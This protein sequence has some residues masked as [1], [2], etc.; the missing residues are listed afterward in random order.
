MTDW[1]PVFHVKRAPRT[2][3]AAHPDHRG[4]LPRSPQ[5]HGEDFLARI[6]TAV[7]NDD[8]S[9]SVQLDALPL[10]GSFLIREPRDGD[11]FDPVRKGGR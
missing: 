3:H 11:H 7:K 9:L 1:M 8:G 6:G 10:T 2:N 4:A 5:L